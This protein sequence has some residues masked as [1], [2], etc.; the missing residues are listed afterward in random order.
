MHDE[1]QQHSYAYSYL[2]LGVVVEEIAQR[3]VDVLSE[4]TMKNRVI[5]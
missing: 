4:K 1:Q 5:L 3:G 2:D